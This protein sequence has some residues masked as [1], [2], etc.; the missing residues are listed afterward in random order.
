M[1]KELLTEFKH[2]KKVHRGGSEDGLASRDIETQPKHAGAVSKAKAQLELKQVRNVKGFFKYTGSK[3]KAKEN[4]GL[5]FNDASNLVTKDS[6]YTLKL[7]YSTPFLPVFSGEVCLQACQVPASTSRVLPI[8]EEDQ[9]SKNLSQ[10][11]ILKSMEPDRMHL[12]ALKE[13][14][15]GTV[16]PFYSIFARSSS[17]SVTAPQPVKYPDLRLPCCLRQLAR[18]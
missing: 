5:L 11:D 12:K 2:R 13:L 8:A 16:K 6:L 1:I 7:I 17:S 9:V 3:R 15:D 18:M 10:L 4:M 14:A